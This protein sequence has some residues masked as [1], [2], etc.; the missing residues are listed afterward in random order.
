MLFIT[1]GPSHFSGSHPWVICA[2]E[3]AKGVT[4]PFCSG[5]TGQGEGIMVFT[6]LLEVKEQRLGIIWQMKLCVNRG[7]GCWVN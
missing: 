2:A 1:N 3:K 7:Q 6:V 4:E 5:F